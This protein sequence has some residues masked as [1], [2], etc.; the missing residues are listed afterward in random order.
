MR[1]L[2]KEELIN[3]DASCLK[4]QCKKDKEKGEC[5]ETS[6]D[7]NI[8]SWEVLRGFLTIRPEALSTSYTRLPTGDREQRLAE[9]RSAHEL[10]R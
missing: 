5:M 3:C 7:G 10:A 9:I 8:I 2:D 4:M 6:Q 1:D